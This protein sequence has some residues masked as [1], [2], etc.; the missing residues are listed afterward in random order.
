MQTGLN[1]QL[2]FSL[3]RIFINITGFGFG[4]CC[5][6]LQPFLACHVKQNVKH[7]SIDEIQGWER[8]YRANFVNSLSGFKPVSLISTINK[9]GI[10]NL[11][12]FC[13]IVHIGA[14]PAY[15]G[16]INRPIDAAPHTLSNIRANGLYTI[17]HIHPEFIAQA[18]QASAKYPEGVNEFREVGLTE[19]YKV[20]FVVPF[21]LESQVQYAMELTEII[22]LVMNNTFLVVGKL[23]HAFLEPSM[24]SKDGFINLDKASSMVSLGMDA[25]YTTKPNVRLQYAKPDRPAAQIDC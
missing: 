18:H 4:Y 9:E 15:I 12:V 7:Y 6:N 16:F 24:L 3:D 11:G 8:F 10:P 19:D 25:Y 21:V 22:P 17:N 1:L 20:D 5:A 14:D 23:L 2:K 13:N